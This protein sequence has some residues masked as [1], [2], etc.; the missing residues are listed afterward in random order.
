M[1]KRVHKQLNIAHSHIKQRSQT[2][3]YIYHKWLNR[4]RKVDIAYTHLISAQKGLNIIAEHIAQKQL[5]LKC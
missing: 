5:N 2:L 1:S 3:I 4:A